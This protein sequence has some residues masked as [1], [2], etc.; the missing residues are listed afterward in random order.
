LLIA[1]RKEIREGIIRALT[2]KDGGR[3][4]ETAL[5]DC[6]QSEVDD[7]LRWV[8]A[9]AL[10]S[11]MPHLRRQTFPEIKRVLNPLGVGESVVEPDRGGIAVFR[12][13]QFTSRRGR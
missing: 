3:E 6:F 7:N 13:Q 4:V 9:N 1:H 8:L 11:A 10:R 5:L 2:M 12:V